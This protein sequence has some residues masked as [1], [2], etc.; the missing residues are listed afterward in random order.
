MVPLISD[1]GGSQSAQS[2]SS[3]LRLSKK[4]RETNNSNE[5]ANS[6]YQ[7]QYMNTKLAY[8]IKLIVL[9]FIFNPCAIVLQEFKHWPER[10]I[11]SNLCFFH[12]CSFS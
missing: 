9:F 10:A 2:G 5:S 7:G 6:C 8:L 11:G 12:D 3:D 4:Q 1:Y